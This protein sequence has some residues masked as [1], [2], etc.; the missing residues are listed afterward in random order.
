MFGTGSPEKPK[1]V[2]FWSMNLDVNR[3]VLG[4]VGSKDNESFKWF[5]VEKFGK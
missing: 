3:L 5:L 2:F 4:G 1:K